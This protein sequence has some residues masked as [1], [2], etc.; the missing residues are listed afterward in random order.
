MTSSAVYACVEQGTSIHYLTRG[1][2]Y[3]AQ[4]AP[5][6]NK[7]VPMRVK[8]YEAYLSQEWKHSLAKRFVEGKLQNSVVFA[9]RSGAKVD[10][11]VCL[12]DDIQRCDDT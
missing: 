8:Q 9:R 5:V 1:G 11:L 7:N 12:H 3:F 4:V 2:T 10:D 6:E